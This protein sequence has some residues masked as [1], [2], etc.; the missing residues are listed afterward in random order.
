M[1]D[2]TGTSAKRPLAVYAIIE[3]K[4]RS[5]WL[6]IGAAF[7]NRDGSINLYLDAV[8]VGTHRIQVREQRPWDDARPA[9]GAGGAPAEA[10]A[11]GAA[12]EA[13]P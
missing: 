7:A 9:N 1:H 5:H 12:L 13:Q 2:A 3:R 11:V 6:K 10:P 4:D 8:P